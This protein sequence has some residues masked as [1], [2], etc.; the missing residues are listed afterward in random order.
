MNKNEISSL[1]GNKEEIPELDNDEKLQRKKEE[2][3]K[4]RTKDLKRCSAKVR[5]F[6]LKYSSTLV[7]DKTNAKYMYAIELSV[8]FHDICFFMTYLL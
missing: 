1:N 7:K 6:E 5:L 8:T 2:K 3:N 4:I